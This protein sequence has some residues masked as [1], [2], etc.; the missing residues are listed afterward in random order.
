[1]DLRNDFTTGN[2][3]YPKNC[4][5]TLHLLDKYS[6]TVVARV[7]QSEGTSFVQR[8][9]RGGGRGGGRGSNGN[10]KSHDSSAYD[11]KYWKDRECYKCHKKGHPATHCPKKPNE[12]DDRSLA[13]TYS[14]AKKLK[15]DLKSMNKAFTMVNTQLAQMKEAKSEISESEGEDK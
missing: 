3:R 10:G 4:H 12:D 15:K 14:S 2:N 5:Q 11:K 6:R 9:G 8:S 7:T 1:V 13:I